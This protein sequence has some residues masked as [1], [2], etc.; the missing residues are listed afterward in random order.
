MSQMCAEGTNK[1]AEG[2][3]MGAEG[4]TRKRVTREEIK[5]VRSAFGRP[6]TVFFGYPDILQVEHLPR[7]P[8]DVLG[9]PSETKASRHPGKLKF[10]AYWERNC[11]KDVFASGGIVRTKDRNWNVHWGKHLHT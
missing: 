11:L 2:T 5:V 9:I 4:T 8:L 6:G 7:G 3:N 10:K 1:G